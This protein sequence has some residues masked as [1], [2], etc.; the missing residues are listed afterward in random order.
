MT[1]VVVLDP[2]SLRSVAAPGTGPPMKPAASAA[3]LPV[4]AWTAWLGPP[5]AE[6]RSTRRLAHLG[7]AVAILALV[8]Y[9]TWRVGWTVPAGG[10]NRRVAW[11]LIAFEA[12]SGKRVRRPGSAGEV[13]SQAENEPRPDLSEARPGTPRGA[14]AIL[15]QAFDPDPDRRPGSASAMIRDLGAA[16]ELE[17]TRPMPPPPPIPVPEAHPSTEPEP[18]ATYVDETDGEIEE[19]GPRGR[20]S[21]F[22]LAR[23]LAR[24]ELPHGLSL[25]ARTPEIQPSERI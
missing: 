15:K 3:S 21:S 5:H 17:S 13:S 1:N 16:L 18:F 22:Q 10:W 25:P 9:L 23:H 19:A 6:P 2:P 24:G 7:G 4:A 20:T 14:A 11:M 12:L 8:I